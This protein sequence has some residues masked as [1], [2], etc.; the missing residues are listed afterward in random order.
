MEL[1]S[2]L[3]TQETLDQKEKE[4]IS[5]VETL[6]G[7]GA[8]FVWLSLVI[9][10]TICVQLLEQRVP[11]FELNAWRFGIPLI[12]YSV[13]IVIMRRWPLISKSEIPAVLLYAA[14]H[15]NISLF[16]TLSFT[17]L[18]AALVQSIDTTMNIISGLFLFS[19]FWKETITLQNTLCSVLC[20]FGVVL[21]I[22]P[23]TIFNKTIVT[24]DNETTTVGIV[25]NGTF[26]NDTI[27]ATK[28]TTTTSYYTKAFKVLKYIFAMIP[29]IALSLS[30]LLVKRRSY[31]VEHWNSVLFWTFLINTLLSV[32]LMAIIESPTLPSN[33]YESVLLICNGLAYGLNMPLNIYAVSRISANTMNIIFSASVM[34]FLLAQY[35]VLSSILPGHRNWIEVLGCALVFTGS[36]FTS[37]MELIKSK[38]REHAELA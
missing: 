33:W 16:Y 31:L 36:A 6:K 10:G 3:S 2:L 7:L 14:A 15:F 30:F 27:T 12:I 34:F 38:M 32:I 4:N 29:G 21:I 9:G 8:A 13:L 28:T 11:E 18:P 17:L 35:T 25:A 5:F 23:G 1:Q 20:I 22:Q 37:I 26:L 24:A 19:L